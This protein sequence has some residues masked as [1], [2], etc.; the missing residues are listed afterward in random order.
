MDNKI[1]RARANNPLYK[2]DYATHVIP[3]PSHHQEQSL[4]FIFSQQGN[5]RA[6][7][8]LRGSFTVQLD[9]NNRGKVN[10]EL[11]KIKVERLTENAK[12]NR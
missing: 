8:G 3:R 5:S 9:R 12:I 7:S 10:E 6:S 2:T 11:Q 1:S 4:D